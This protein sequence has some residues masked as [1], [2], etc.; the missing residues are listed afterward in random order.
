VIH[1]YRIATTPPVIDGSLNDEVWTVADSTGDYIQ[2]DPDN[3]RGMSEPTRIQFAYDDRYIYIAILSEDSVPGAIAS[4]LGRR[5]DFPSTDYVS[6]GFDPRHD[7]LTGYVFQTNPSSVQVDFSMSDDDRQDR[8]YNAVWEVRT[9]ISARGWTAEFRIPFS[10]MRFTVSPQAGQVWG[11]QA[12]RLIRRKGEL[13]TWV[14][15]PRGER[16]DVS[17][18]GH[19]V[20]DR[21]LAA[22]RRLEITPY[23]LTRGE[24][25][26]AVDSDGAASDFG[27]ASGADLRLG[28]GSAA[29]LAATINP[30][31]GQVEQDP[32]VLNL[33]VFETFFPEKRS[34]FL[35]D[36]RVRPPLLLSAL[37]LPAYRRSTKPLCRECRR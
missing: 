26:A 12:E 5:D 21:P 31:F 10:Q 8:D 23:V 24:R 4:G 1:A 30:D 17:L 34:F 20:F 16:G 14:G 11:L 7:H 19:L 25:S 3:G 28:L 33:S 18:Y 2:R 36:S 27:A 35:E 22:S 37:S 15:K 6:V 9:Q 29:T 13:G 32:A